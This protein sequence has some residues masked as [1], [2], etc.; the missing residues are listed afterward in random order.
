MWSGRSEKGGRRLSEGSK[1]SKVS[2]NS[3]EGKGERK[4]AKGGS[5]KSTPNSTKEKCRNPNWMRD[6]VRHDG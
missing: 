1:F 6:Q 5:L 4:K 2:G 3:E